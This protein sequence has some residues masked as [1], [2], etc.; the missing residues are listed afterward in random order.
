MGN[1]SNQTRREYEWQI[2]ER[3]TVAQVEQF[4]EVSI[5]NWHPEIGRCHENVDRW[6]EA[7]PECAA[8]RGWVV[9]ALWRGNCLCYRPLR[10]Q[11]LRRTTI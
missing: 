8:M 4:K 5:D 11:R 9:Y 1:S 6:I 3:L 2:S 7:N 10:H